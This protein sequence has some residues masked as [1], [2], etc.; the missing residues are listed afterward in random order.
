M[1]LAVAGVV[2][3]ALFRN[4]MADPYVLGISSGAAFGVA[5]A[6]FLGLVSGATGA[7]SVPWPPSAEQL[8]QL[9]SFSLSREVSGDPL[10][11]FYLLE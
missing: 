5:F 6:A 3:Q 2:F 4:P 11:P 9:S 8:E 1:V 10:S 7:W